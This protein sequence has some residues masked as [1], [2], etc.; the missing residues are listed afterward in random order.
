MALDENGKA[1]AN[2]GVALG[3]YLHNG[4]PSIAITH[5]SEQY[6]QLF[7]N[8]GKLNFTDVSNISKSRAPRP[9]SSAGATPST[10]S[11][12]MAGSTSS[13]STAMST[14]RLIDAK[15]GIFYREPGQ[16]FLNQRDGAFR[17]VSDQVGPALK[18]PRVGRDSP[19][20]TSLMTASRKSWSRIS[21][22]SP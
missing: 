13:P 16:L 10:I 8:D 18:V 14:R 22:A 21:R 5:F 11:I 4:L 12:T 20:A 3:D 6:L 2:M 15:I 19:S 9:T 7:R 17:D 1:L